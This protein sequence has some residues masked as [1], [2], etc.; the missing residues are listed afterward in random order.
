MNRDFSCQNL[1]NMNGVTWESSYV[2]CIQNFSIGLCIY[3]L[4]K[5]VACLSF[6]N[7]QTGKTLVILNRCADCSCY[8]DIFLCKRQFPFLFGLDSSDFYKPPKYD[9]LSVAAKMI[10]LYVCLNHDCYRIHR[11]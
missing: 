6:D 11:C 9:F 2:I 4:I 1:L 3:S 7:T 8:C 5:I 10:F